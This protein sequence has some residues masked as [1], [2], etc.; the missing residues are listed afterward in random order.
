M[1][2]VLGVTHLLE[3]PGALP[4]VARLAA[5][6]FSRHA[7]TVHPGLVVAVLGG[8]VARERCRAGALIV[9]PWQRFT[10]LV[11]DLKS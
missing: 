4:E 9:T 3:E 5:E 10:G 11:A 2:I 6:R 7:T 8:H 1:V